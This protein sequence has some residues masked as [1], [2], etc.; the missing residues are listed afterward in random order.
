MPECDEIPHTLKKLYEQKGVTHPCTVVGDSKH[1]TW[2][3][4][5]PKEPLLLRKFI[6]S[7][8]LAKLDTAPWHKEH[9][10]D[11]WYCC[12]RWLSAPG[13]PGASNL[14]PKKGTRQGKKITPKPTSSAEHMTSSG[15]D[16]VIVLLLSAHTSS[17]SALMH[18]LKTDTAC[19]L[20]SAR[21][22]TKASNY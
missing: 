2:S 12:W 7:C 6:F 11:V 1:S 5:E 4:T 14:W 21:L 15:Y 20:Q 18:S 10:S 3:K 16:W 17:R 19:V 9:L 8:S 13:E 22:Q